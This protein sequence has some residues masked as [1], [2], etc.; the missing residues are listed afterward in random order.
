[1]KEEDLNAAQYWETRLQKHWG[2]NAVGFLGLGDA[3]NRALYRVKKHVFRRAVKRLAIDLAG[4]KVLDIGSGTGFVVQQWRELGVAQLIGCDLSPFAANHLSAQYP[5]Y[6]FVELDIGSPLASGFF[7]QN[8]FDCVSALD[9]LYHIV[10]DVAYQQA[11]KHISRVLR[12]GGY[13]IVAD[14]F[15]HGGTV[16]GQHQVS[17]SIETLRGWLMDVGL[18]IAYRTPQYV[19]MNY[20]VDSDSRLLHLWWQKLSYQLGRSERRGL[21][22]GR[23]LAPLEILLTDILREGSSTELAICRKIAK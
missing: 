19:L 21:W 5:D 1:V 4:V 11:L 6:E 20:P 16:R 15:V 7:A 8:S 14:N 22:L 23:V 2:P 3:Y 10:D 9:V 18:E 13:L 17:H 12:L